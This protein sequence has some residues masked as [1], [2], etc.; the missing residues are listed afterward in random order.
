VGAQYQSSGKRGFIWVIH[1]YH[2]T[3][4]TL[5][6]AVSPHGHALEALLTVMVLFFDGQFMPA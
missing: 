4:D 1:D 3:D 5:I 6:R 2:G